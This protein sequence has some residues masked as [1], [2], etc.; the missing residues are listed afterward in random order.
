VGW[1]EG[2]GLAQEPDWG[3]LLTNNPRVLWG[4]VADV[5]KAAKAAEGER[6]TGRRPAAVCT[7]L[8]ELY[9]VLFPA[10]FT[11]AEFPEALNHLLSG[12]SQQAFAVRM[13]FS[14]ATASRL[15]SGKTPPSVELMERISAALD[16]RPSYFREYRAH[17]LGQVITEVFLATPALSAD[18]IKRLAW[19]QS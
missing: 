15:L 9:E 1:D 2:T 12:R 14:Q 7:S 18:A 11:E 13:G 19:V 5:V 10:Q 6:K 8:D 3:E 17:K 16:V 4:I